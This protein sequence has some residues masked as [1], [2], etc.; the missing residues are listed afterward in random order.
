MVAKLF[1]D[2]NVLLYVHDG[3]EREKQPRAT[4]LV[5]RI[6]AER[7]G[8]LSTQVLA[9]F[10]WNATRHLRTP[11]TIS[12]AR[13]QVVMLSTALETF[14]LGLPIFLEALRGVQAYG[15]PYWDAQ[16]WATA[17]LNRIPVVVSEGFQPGRTLEGVQFI[18]P[19]DPNFDLDALLALP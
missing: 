10:F 3:W 1:L 11:L 2:S 18:D 8:S 13:D 6:L 15:M 7:I 12:E 5:R 16:I 14:D 4:A 19:F 17:R 9:E